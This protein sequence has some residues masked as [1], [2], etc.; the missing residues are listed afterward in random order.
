MC[1]RQSTSF[2]RSH[3]TGCS[4]RHSRSR[5]VSATNGSGSSAI[6]FRT[7]GN[8][9]SGVER[10]PMQGVCEEA[11]AHPQP[12]TNGPSPAITYHPLLFLGGPPSP[13]TVD[14]RPRGRAVRPQR[15]LPMEQYEQ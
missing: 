11:A 2:I 1:A 10:S 3:K 12:S 7:I 5:W 6:A 14:P 8:L 4:S 13:P 15:G 9:S